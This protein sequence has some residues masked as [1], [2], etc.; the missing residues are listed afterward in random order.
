MRIKEIRF[1]QD[2]S[3]QKL[4]LMS[5]ISQTTISHIENGL[6]IPTDEQKEKIANALELP[7]LVID[8]NDGDRG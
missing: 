3:Q 6:H 1:Y 2:I 8:W 7:E 5:G 4:A